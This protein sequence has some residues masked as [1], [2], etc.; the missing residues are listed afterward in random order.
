MP[1]RLLHPL[2]RRKALRHL[3]GCPPPRFVLVVC[4]GNICRSPY[5]AALL[6]HALTQSA[7]DAVRVESGGCVGSSG[8]PCP[9]IA[10]EVA[11]AR[12]LDL[13]RHRSQTLTPHNVGAADLVVVMDRAQRGVLRRLFNGDGRDVLVLGDLDPDP[14][15]TRQIEDPVEQSREIFERSYSRIERCVRQLVQA[16]ADGGERTPSRGAAPLSQRDQ[17][18]ERRGRQEQTA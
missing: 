10:V 7:P 13:S 9:P 1:E 12:G 18:G 15:D 2:R 8:R 3:R 16:V 17:D 11:A 4:H 6:R 5:A 14:I